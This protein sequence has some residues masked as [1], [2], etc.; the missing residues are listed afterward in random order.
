MRILFLESWPMWIY[1]L[2]RGFRDIGHEVLISGILSKEKLYEDILSYKPTLIFSMGWTYEH[3]PEK[4]GWLK[5]CLEITHI[6]HIYWAT[7]DPTHTKSFTV[8]LI[9]NSKMDFIFT[10]CPAR[11]D[12]YKKMGIPSAPLDFAYQPDVHYRA[13]IDFKYAKSIAVVANAYPHILQKYPD[14]YR[15]KSIKTLIKPLIKASIRVDF[16]GEDWD[17]MQAYLGAEIPEEWMHGYLNYLEA[18][19]VYASSNIIIGLQNHENQLTQRTYEILGSEG[20]LITSDTPEIRR[21]F[22]PGQDLVVPSCSKETV[23]LVKYYTKNNRARE[24]IR[25][26]GKETVEKNHTYQHRALYII[27]VLKTEGIIR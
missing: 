4:Q 1:G 11:V 19:K 2:P 23:N 5:E 27:E 20:F 13:P 14:H 24:R 6:P 16:W 9:Q 15:I 22:Q 3:S 8:P 12:Y 21:L 7:E 26:Q 18:T 10:I 25:K 17:K